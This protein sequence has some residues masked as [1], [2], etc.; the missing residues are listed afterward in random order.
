MYLRLT[1]VGLSDED[2]YDYADPSK[3]HR[4]QY[5]PDDIKD[6]EFYKPNTNSTYEKA[7]ADNYE[8]LKQYYRTS[9]LRDLNRK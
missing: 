3:W 9:K 1:P 6:V 5:L 7:L 8:K 4:I 2:K